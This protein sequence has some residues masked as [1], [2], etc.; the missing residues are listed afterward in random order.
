[1]Q[2]TILWQPHRSLYHMR[3]LIQ[4]SPLL[5]ISLV[6]EDVLFFSYF[7]SLWKARGEFHQSHHHGRIQVIPHQQMT[8]SPN[9]TSWKFLYI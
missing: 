5:S 3:C 8:R 9:L 4:H 2:P 7:S 6:Y 1:M